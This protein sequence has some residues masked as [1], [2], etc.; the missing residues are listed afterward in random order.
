MYMIFHLFRAPT[1]LC[2]LI[3][4]LLHKTFNAQISPNVLISLQPWAM[5]KFGV[6]IH[7]VHRIEKFNAQHH[8]SR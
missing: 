8:T 7:D 3:F 1:I 2:S 5:L 6:S 4:F